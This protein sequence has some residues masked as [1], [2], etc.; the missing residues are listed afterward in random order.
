MP[1]V[2]SAAMN[3]STSR[4][5]WC[6]VEPWWSSRYTSRLSTRQFS[7]L[8]P[9]S[10]L[11]APPPMRSAAGERCSAA[12]RGLASLLAAVYSLMPPAT[13]LTDCT[14]ATP[15]MYRSKR[16]TAFINLQSRQAS[17]SPVFSA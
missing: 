13:L 5:T 16:S 17:S 4:V 8:S 2:C 3:F 11:A 6:K 12:Q 15:L 7:L 9:S 14:P 10:G 1:A